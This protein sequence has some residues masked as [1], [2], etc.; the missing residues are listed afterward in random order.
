MKTQQLTKV[1][2]IHLLFTNGYEKDP[3]TR[4][5]NVTESGIQSGCY[6]YDK[7]SNTKCAVGMCMT[8]VGL[9]KFGEFGGMVNAL[10]EYMTTRFKTK[11]LKSY[12]KKEFVGHSISFWMRVQEL[13]D[14]QE[15]WDEKGLTQSGQ[16]CKRMLM[17]DYSK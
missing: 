15:F 7:E 11:T 1:E 9:K 10:D 17:L 13:H 6:Y 5:I 8:S 3:S 14:T 16:G 12:L 4:A 2:I